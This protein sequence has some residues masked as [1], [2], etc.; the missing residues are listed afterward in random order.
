M[1][2]DKIVT[3]P[4]EHL[5]ITQISS[6]N[7]SNSGVSTHLYTLCRQELRVLS[8][9]YVLEV[10]TKLNKIPFHC[11][12]K[13]NLT[14]SSSAQVLVPGIGESQELRSLSLFHLRHLLLLGLINEP[15]LAFLFLAADPIGKG[16]ENCQKIFL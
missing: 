6:R 11:H 4:L 1:Q 14:T 16:G 2:H 3:N 9:E 10:R 7:I 8:W 12:N 5:C 13:P 15:S